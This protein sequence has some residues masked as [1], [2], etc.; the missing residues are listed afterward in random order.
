MTKNEA[1][2]L[3]ERMPYITT[4]GSPSERTRIEFY[5]TAVEGTDPIQWIKVIKSN[6][7]LEHFPSK[8]RIIVSQSATR[9]SD[10]AKALLER[11]L[12]GALGIRED[13]V[14]KFINE[15]LLEN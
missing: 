14:D 13:E 7:V 2:E 12:A 5:K 6:Y 10:T 9:Y 1:L 8:K 4:F 15:Y 11:Q 3:I